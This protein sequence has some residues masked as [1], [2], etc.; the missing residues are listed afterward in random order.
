MKKS[1][2]GQIIMKQTL[3]NTYK[4]W[5][6]SFLL[7]LG[8]LI[9][10]VDVVYMI[11]LIFS[12]LLGQA[13]GYSLFLDRIRAVAIFNLVYFIITLVYVKNKLDIVLIKRIRINKPSFKSIR[14]EMNFY[15]SS[16]IFFAIIKFIIFLIK[17]YIK[18]RN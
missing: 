12:A 4:K 18:S 14:K 8:I 6:D 5:T 11:Y 2:F 7:K 17:D 9:L 13:I 16:T 10:F 1:C 15:I 3:V